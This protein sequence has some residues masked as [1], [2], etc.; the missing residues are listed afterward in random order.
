MMMNMIKR[1]SGVLLA[2]CLVAPMLTAQSEGMKSSHLWSYS[3]PVIKYIAATDHDPIAKLSVQLEVTA[4]QL[5]STEII[6]VQ[7]MLVS[8]DGKH[9][10]LLPATYVAGSNR[11][12]YINR[13]DKLNHSR[14]YPEVALSDIHAW[15]DVKAS[16]FTITQKVPFESWMADATLM[17]QEELSGCASCGVQNYS[18]PLV[19][20]NIPLFQPDLTTMAYQQPLTVRQKE[21]EEEFVSFINFRVGRYELLKDYKDNPNELNKI[22][23]FIS[24]ALKLNEIGATIGLVQITGF[25]S[26]EGNFN[27]NRTLSHNRANTLMNY[28]KSSY[29]ELVKVARFEIIEGGEDWAGLKKA[30][31][32]SSASFKDQV[33]AIIDKYPT[34]VEREA[35]IKALE[36]GAVYKTLLEEYYPPLRRTT[37]K[38]KYKV[39]NYTTEELP[40]IYQKKRELLSHGELVTLA[41]NYYDK[42]GMNPVEIF[43]YA[44]E[45]YGVK[46]PIARYNFALAILKWEPE[47]SRE[48]LELI[49][50]LPDSDDVKYLHAT[51]LY[52]M[53]DR[54]AANKLMNN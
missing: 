49:K 19:A 11:Y 48:A 3:E 20:L 33:V 2:L 41:T 44:C 27:S 53:G 15:N 38:T 50:S 16:S 14:V 12:K 23:E 21:Y 31:S 9:Q 52:Q 45:K 51:A 8:K 5:K 36:G 35:D 43:R 40:N 34:D 7:P 37:I 24:K 30:V 6:K 42:K 39:R 18:N 1:L 32:E 10:C 47:K 26:P 22:N 25:A 28:L 17:I 54:D 29:P 13:A 46:D 4:Q